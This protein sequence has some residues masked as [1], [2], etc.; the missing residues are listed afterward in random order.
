MSSSLMEPDKRKAHLV[1]QIKAASH[2]SE[3]K[4]T[5]KAEFWESPKQV[6][7]LS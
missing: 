7:D 2:H 4:N 6:Y 3:G 5:S 1:L